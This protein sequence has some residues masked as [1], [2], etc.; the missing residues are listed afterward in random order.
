MQLGIV[1]SRQGPDRSE[2]ADEE[3][4]RALM[5][6]GRTQGGRVQVIL[7]HPRQCLPQAWP[8]VTTT[9]RGVEH[10]QNFKGSQVAVAVGH[11]AS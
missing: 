10:C 7:G 1:G 6:I 4:R 3:T 8:T 9:D 5:P 2:A 11:V